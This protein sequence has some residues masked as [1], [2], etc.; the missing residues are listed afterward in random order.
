MKYIIILLLI[1]MI[2][3]QTLIVRQHDI[4]FSH[5]VNGVEIVET[6]SFVTYSIDN[7]KGIITGRS[8][9]HMDIE[10]YMEGFKII[11]IKHYGVAL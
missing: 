3:C 11:S 5:M 2:G 1:T 7:S 4:T 9:N 8:T 6:M 10:L